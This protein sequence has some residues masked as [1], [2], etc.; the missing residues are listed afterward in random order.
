M[1]VLF[2]SY[3]CFR[4]KENSVEKLGEK[5]RVNIYME[6]EIERKKQRK[7]ETDRQ[8]IREKESRHKYEDRHRERRRNRHTEK[9]R[10]RVKKRRR[11]LEI[12]TPIIRSRLFYLYDNFLGSTL[13]LEIHFKICNYRIHRQ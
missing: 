3:L 1:I 4:D 9:E 2:C 11:G 6:T 5:E 10:L 13:G 7:R 8:K 12:V